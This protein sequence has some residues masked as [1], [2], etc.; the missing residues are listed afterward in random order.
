R[1]V[2]RVGVRIGLAERA[3][4][5]RIEEM[6]VWR[7]PGGPVYVRVRFDQA[8][9]PLGARVDGADPD[10]VRRGGDPA[11]GGGRRWWDR[12]TAAAASPGRSQSTQRGLA[13]AARDG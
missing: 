8:V 3:L 13:Q 1:E 12:R 5:V 10:E 9:P 2:A 7:A 11:F 4:P 6:D